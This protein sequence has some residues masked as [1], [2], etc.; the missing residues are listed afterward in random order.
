MQILQAVYDD[1]CSKIAKFV[2]L[3]NYSFRKFVFARRGLYT[4]ETLPISS[5]SSA[6][7]G[8]LNGRVKQCSSENATR[9]KRKG[10]SK[11]PS[12]KR[13]IMQI[14]PIKIVNSG[15]T[16]FINRATDSTYVEKKD[17]GNNTIGRG[18]K[19]TNTPGRKLDGGNLQQK[20]EGNPARKREEN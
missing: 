13:G 2:P 14:P 15:E 17:D 19:H 4:S 3:E 8:D 9:G 11:R 6:W 12:T 10:Q 18:G 5:I 20:T 16:Y 7:A 1:P